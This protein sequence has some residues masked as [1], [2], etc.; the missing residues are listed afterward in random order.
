MLAKALLPSIDCTCDGVTRRMIRFQFSKKK[1]AI[2]CSVL[3]LSPPLA[4]A[5]EKSAQEYSNVAEEKA[6]SEEAPLVLE[7][8]V[9]RI[10]RQSFK[11]KMKKLEAENENAASYQLNGNIDSSAGKPAEEVSIDWDKWRNRVTRSIWAKFCELL[12]GG[13]AIMLGGTLI[14]L[15]NAPILRFPVGTSASYSFNVNNER[16]L[17][18]VR[19]TSSSGNKQFDEIIRRSVQSIDGKQLLRFPKGSRR[20]LVSASA[21]LYTT[22]HGSYTKIPFG[23]V[24]RYQTATAQQH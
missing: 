20:I 23:D 8:A 5:Q 17:S 16:Q 24:E 4:L 18:N 10:S 2:L 1:F 15:G 3:F 11:S 19:I 9:Q 14:K 22:K 6:S 12:N 21:K 7:G 13:D